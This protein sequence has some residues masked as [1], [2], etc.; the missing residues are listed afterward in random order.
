[1][2]HIRSTVL[3]VKSIWL[4][5]QFEIAGKNLLVHNLVS[6][7]L[8]HASTPFSLNGTMVKF[9]SSHV[10]PDRDPTTRVHQSKSKFKL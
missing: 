9:P 7:G 8:E 3:G 1:M 6:I 2:V 4:A 10:F 5:C